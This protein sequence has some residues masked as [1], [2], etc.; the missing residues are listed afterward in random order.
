MPLERKTIEEIKDGTRTWCREN[1]SIV[2]KDKDGK[3]TKLG[4]KSVLFQAMNALFDKEGAP[5]EKAPEEETEEKSTDDTDDDAPAGGKPKGG[6]G[7]GRKAMLDIVRKSIAANA[8]ETTE[9]GE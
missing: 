1:G 2:A 4:A 6:G 9:G 3:V 7:F 5:A 8:P